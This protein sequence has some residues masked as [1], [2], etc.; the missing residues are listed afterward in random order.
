VAGAAQAELF[1]IA[2]QY[3]LCHLPTLHLLLPDMC[4]LVVVGAASWSVL[5]VK[6]HTQLS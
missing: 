1:K 5:P 4:C 6:P 2:V 3:A